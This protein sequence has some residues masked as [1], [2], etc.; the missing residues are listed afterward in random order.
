[1]GQTVAVTDDPVR[2]A[3]LVVGLSVASDLGRG[4]DDGQGLRTTVLAMR[5]AEHLDLP[6]PDRGTLYWLSLLRFVGCTATATEMAGALG[7]EL[8]VSAAFAAVD[9]KDL[10]AVLRTAASTV[11]ARPDRL[12]SFL[13][14]APAV[15]AEH[16]TA[17]C[18]VAQA[19]AARLGLSA[20]VVAALGQVFERWDGGGNPGRTAG[21][22]LH[23]AVRV[24]QVAHLA[25]LILDG[26]LGDRTPEAVAREL[27]RR[28]G[29]ALD[30]DAAVRCAEAAGDLFAEHPPADA[31]SVLAAEPEPR[32]TTAAIDDVLAVFGLVADLKAP[33]FHGH[34][35]RVSALAA[36]AASA[37]NC[38]AADV[39][40]IGRAGLVGDIGRVA[41]SSRIWGKPGQLTEGEREHV[42]LHPLYTGR[43]LSRVPELAPVAALAATHHE[44]SDGSGY[45][46]GL[47]GTALSLPAALLAAADLYVGTGEDR[48]Y[49]P[50][51]ADPDR[52][53]LLQQAADSGTLPA[54]AVHAV[55][56]AAGRR[57]VPVAAVRPGPL[58]ERE[59]DVLRA[60]ALG[61]TNQATARRLR[62]SAK[63]VNTHLEHVYAKL[64][65]STRAAAIVQAMQNGWLE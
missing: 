10:R 43:V 47:S 56:A 53:A 4:L 23:P 22:A 32:H 52:E 63:T 7:N 29:K 44:R 35:T 27:R 37:A 28:A 6:G 38:P 31:A 51:L 13:A 3:A 24:W 8:A 18:E 54:E 21:S 62:I 1:V 57:P 9:T 64:G 46:R 39:T 20:D 36:E 42:R 12:L 14:K 41:I 45:H 48:P 50:A 33:C 65:V 17:S 59:L 40:A 58:T 19:I 16:E 61:L 25:D 5:L 55:L 26:A 34:S 60:V 30:P 49:R 2:V 11:G 15:I